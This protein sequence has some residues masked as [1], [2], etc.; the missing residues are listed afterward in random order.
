[1]GFRAWGFWVWGLGFRGLGRRF[2][3]PGPSFG[4]LD[5]EGRGLRAGS[6]GS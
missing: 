3:V 1:M 4:V 6:K 5:W 2:G